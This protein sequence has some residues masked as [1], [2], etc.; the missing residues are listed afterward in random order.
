[1]SPNFGIR[2]L[3]RLFCRPLFFFH[4]LRKFEV[5][6]FVVVAVLLRCIII[7][8][9]VIFSNIFLYTYSNLDKEKNSQQRLSTN[10][11]ME[12]TV[13]TIK[14][15]FCVAHTFT[16]DITDIINNDFASNNH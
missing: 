16:T 3:Y 7:T 6:F 12:L 11:L 13:Q 14:T 5:A 8:L 15:V 2:L 10:S 1:M 9:F 4:F